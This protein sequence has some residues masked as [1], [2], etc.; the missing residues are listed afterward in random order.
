MR[1]V[2]D[3]MLGKLARILRMLGYD[4]LYFKNIED[5]E[6]AWISRNE[7]RILITRDTILQRRFN[8]FCTILLQSQQIDNEIK[9]L[10]QFLPEISC[11]QSFSRCIEC[12]N[13]L[14]K[15]IKNKLENNVPP[16]VFST[17]DDF[18]YCKNC[19]KIYWKGT[20]VENMKKRFKSWCL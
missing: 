20:H 11:A 13:L 9:E 19:G 12:N 1:F 5:A 15:L 6:L 7:N 14:I 17:H 16:Y 18:A 3:C 10:K 8:T 4:T 2:V